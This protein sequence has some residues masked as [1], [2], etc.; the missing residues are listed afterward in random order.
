[1]K[2]ITIFIKSIPLMNCWKWKILMMIKLVWKLSKLIIFQQ[3]S[4]CLSFLSKHLII[5]KNSR[6]VAV[7][8]N[9]F[10]R[11]DD[12]IFFL[13]WSIFLLKFMIYHFELCCWDCQEIA[14]STLSINLLLDLSFS[15]PLQVGFPIGDRLDF[16]DLGSALMM[17]LIELM[18]ESRR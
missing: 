3:W 4:H 15:V 5:N 8:K 9:T 11:I 17:F 12:H 16:F 14:F 6:I 13:K 10:L 18:I 7:S 2:Q 1:M